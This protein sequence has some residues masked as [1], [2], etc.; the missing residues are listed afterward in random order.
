[1][2][3]FL[4][5]YGGQLTT[6]LLSVM[7]L[8]TLLILVPKLLRVRQ[9]ARELEHAE[10]L[11]A[12]E[13][14]ITLPRSDEQTTAAGRTASLVPM[15]VVCAAATV[16]CFLAANKSDSLL[17]VTLTVWIVAGVVSLAAITGGVALV[18]R[19]AQ[20]QTGDEDEEENQPV[21]GERE[22]R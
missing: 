22:R 17:A 19:L 20:L 11:K 10:H 8:G 5:K 9:I 3:A 1:M 4:D 21:R 6:L 18:G 12:L 2:D 13:K 7:M 16:T 15:V 14:G